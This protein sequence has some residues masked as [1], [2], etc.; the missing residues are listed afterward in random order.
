[1]KKVSLNILALC[2]GIGVLTLGG[3]LVGRWGR[4]PE[5]ETWS[6]QESVAETGAPSE[7][8][9]MRQIRA[10]TE[11]SPIGAARS[12]WHQEDPWLYGVRSESGLTVPGIPNDDPVLTN[13]ILPVRVIA[14]SGGTTGG[15]STKELDR[16]AVKYAEAYNVETDLILKTN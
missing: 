12:V 16:V 2:L 11:R 1:M 4:I 13:G 10:L 6:R 5:V 9:I 7:R 15:D 8:A 14:W 3:Y